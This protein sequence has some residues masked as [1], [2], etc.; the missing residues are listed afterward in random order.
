MNEER[1]NED[2]KNEDERM[3]EYE[4]ENG[5]NYTTVALYVDILRQCAGRVWFTK[6]YF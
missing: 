5:N 2:E 6:R 1:T 3:K 4:K